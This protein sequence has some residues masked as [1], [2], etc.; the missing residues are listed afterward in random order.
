MIYYIPNDTSEDGEED[1][2]AVAFTAGAVVEAAGAVIAPIGRLDLRVPDT[3]ARAIGGE[4]GETAEED[5]VGDGLLTNG[6]LWRE[7]LHL[8]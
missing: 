3:S 7:M 4:K 5:W 8:A 2:T 6:R 1:V